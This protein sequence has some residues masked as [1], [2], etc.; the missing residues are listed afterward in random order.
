ML[1]VRHSW[2]WNQASS[3]QKAYLLEAPGPP[4]PHPVKG[5]NRFVALPAHRWSIIQGL[6]LFPGLV[7]LS[8]IL[9]FLVYCSIFLDFLRKCL[10]EELL[11][12]LSVEK[13]SMSLHLMDNLALVQ[14]SRIKIIFLQ[15][16]SVFL[17]CPSTFDVS[18]SWQSFFLCFF[19]VIYFLLQD[20]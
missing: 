13:V 11:N 16:S 17:H 9:C 7:P 6:L 1:V 14:K 3:F 5:A 20:V 18:C 12:F 15:T 10:W 8:W 19:N 2:N 4:Q